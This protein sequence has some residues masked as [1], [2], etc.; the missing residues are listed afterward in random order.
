MPKDLSRDEMARFIKQKL[1]DSKKET[2]AAKEILKEQIKLGKVTTITP[3]KRPRQKGGFVNRHEKAAM[4]AEL[5]RNPD[6]TG[7]EFGEKFGYSPKSSAKYAMMD[8]LRKELQGVQLPEMEDILKADLV[9]I[10]L[11]QKELLRRLDEE[12]D[13]LSAADI[14]NIM[15]NSFRRVRLLEGKKDDTVRITVEQVKDLEE[16]DLDG[17]LSSLV[18]VREIHKS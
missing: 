7:P 16:K 18:T 5:V 3:F 9:T 15:N 10:A 17:L 13:N 6:I 4:M 12:P 8:R 14:N 2:K 1:E 11:S